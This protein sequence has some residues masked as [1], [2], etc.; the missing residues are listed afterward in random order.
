MCERNIDWLPLALPNQGP[1]PQ[2]RHVPQPG[3]EPATFCFAARCPTHCATAVRAEP[4]FTVG[5]T[6]EKLKHPIRGEQL[7][8]YTIIYCLQILSN[9]IK[10]FMMYC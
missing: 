7:Q 4:S 5:K 1:G 9:N 8:C 2:P 10:M 3:I 6:L